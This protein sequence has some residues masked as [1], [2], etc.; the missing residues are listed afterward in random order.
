M[1]R[2]E[3]DISNQ[4]KESNELIFLWVDNDD[5]GVFIAEE[6]LSLHDKFLME[7]YSAKTFSEFSEKIGPAGRVFV[8]CFIDG[9]EERAPEP[10]DS[11]ADLADFFIFSDM[12]FPI[13]QLTQETYYYHR[14]KLPK[15]FTAQVIWTEYGE[16]IGLFAKKD[17]CEVKDYLERQGY[18]ATC[19]KLS[20]PLEIYNYGKPSG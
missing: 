6:A 14:E 20:I 2:K 10:N 4:I 17:F 18:S 1:N 5:F 8:T 15:E 7:K 11:L 12:E 9:V 16:E 3:E 13:T 19:K